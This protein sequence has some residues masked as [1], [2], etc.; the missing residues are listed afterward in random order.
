MVG[1]DIDLIE[2]QTGTTIGNY[3]VASGMGGIFLV[4][5]LQTRVASILLGTVLMLGCRQDVLVPSYGV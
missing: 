2:T 3:S 1:N 5:L 4:P